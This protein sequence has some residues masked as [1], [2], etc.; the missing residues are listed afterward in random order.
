MA[1]LNMSISF[2]NADNKSEAR[3]QFIQFETKLRQASDAQ[4]DTEVLHS[5]LLHVLLSRFLSCKVESRVITFLLA[6]AGGKLEVKVWSHPSGGRE[7]GGKDEAL[8]AEETGD[9]KKFT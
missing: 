6:F 7:K 2:Y 5:F 4:L 8:Q 1:P 9:D 3:N